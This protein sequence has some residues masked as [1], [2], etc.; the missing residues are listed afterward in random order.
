M[1]KVRD[2]TSAGC[3]RRGERDCVFPAITE[4]NKTETKEKKRVLLDKE[5]LLFLLEMIIKLNEWL[6]FGKKVVSLHIAVFTDIKKN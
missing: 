2:Y 4:R 5:M 1:R 3:A 6:R